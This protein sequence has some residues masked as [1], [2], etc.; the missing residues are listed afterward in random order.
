MEGRIITR[1]SFQIVGVGWTGPYTSRW[2]IPHLWKEFV[3][4][5]DEIPD[6]MRPGVFISP[7]HDRVTDFTCYIGVQVKSAEK[8]PDGMLALT[9]PSQRYAVF[10]HRG[11]MDTV[12]STYQK[13]R[14][15]IQKLGYEKDYSTLSLEVFDSRYN[16]A[17][18]DPAST[19]NVYE[20]YIPIKK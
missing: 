3:K 13:A 17:V 20:I 14:A 10:L 15:W 2:E 4:R 9:I 19:N 18:D 11:P 16:P 7:C 6:Q 12:P 1:T 8:I 5:V